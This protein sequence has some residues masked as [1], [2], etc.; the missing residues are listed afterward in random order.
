MKKL[1]IFHT[2]VIAFIVLC[3]SVSFKLDNLIELLIFTF[4]LLFSVAYLFAIAI[5]KDK[6]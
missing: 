3:F 6:K 5:I 4:A 1:H 2:L